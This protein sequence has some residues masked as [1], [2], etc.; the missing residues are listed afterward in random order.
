MDDMVNL[1]E[2]SEQSILEN[3]RERY[4]KQIIYV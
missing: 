2:L 4:Q 3:L 1:P